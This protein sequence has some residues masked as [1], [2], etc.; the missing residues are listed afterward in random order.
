MYENYDLDEIITPVKV[1]SFKKL[2]VLSGYDKNKIAKLIK[3]FTE[4]FPIGYE[5]QRDGIQRKAPNLK[6]RVG[7]EIDLWNKVMKEVK[8]RRYAGPFKE[9]PFKDYI[10]SPIGLVPKDNAKD[11]RLI[12]HLSFPHSGKS[13]NSET[14]KERCTIKYPDF[15]EAIRKCLEEDRNQDIKGNPVIIGKSD[16]KSAF[17]FVPIK[18]SDWMLLVMKA[19]NPLDHQW[20]YFV[21]KCMPF[22]ASISCAHFQ[23]ISNALAHIQKFR[24]GKKPVNYLD[25]FL[26]ATLKR[27]LCDGQMNEFIQICKELGILISMDKTEWGSTCMIFLGL[28]IDTKNKLVAI[29][30]N[31]VEKAKELIDKILSM[32]KIKMHNLQKL[33][34]FLNFLCRCIIPGRAFTQCLYAYMASLKPHHHIRVNVELKLDL[35]TWQTFLCHPSVYSRP[36]LDYSKEWTAEVLNFYTDST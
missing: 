27:A 30:A 8:L 11:Q 28:L 13:I 23:E 15:E 10:Q 36:F 34:G 7:N 26:F 9:V 3:N 5:G 35:R 29:P 20:Y 4:G 14:L 24:S 18:K 17:R 31:K 12:F 33:T 25:D 22:G 6:L 21:D 2:L 19:K 16:L 32:K 1:N